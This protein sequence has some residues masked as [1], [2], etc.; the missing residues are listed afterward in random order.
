MSTATTTNTINKP[1][2]KKDIKINAEEC[3]DQFGDDLYEQLV[4]TFVERDYVEKKEQIEQAIKVKDNK[5]LKYVCHTFKTTSRMLCIEDFALECHAIETEAV[6]DNVD[7]NLMQELVDE[8]LI[9]FHSIYKDA[10]EI[11]NKEFNKNVEIIDK[12][13]K[14]EK[15]LKL[16]SR[17]LIEDSEN[18]ENMNIEESKEVSDK[19]KVIKSASDS[20]IGKFISLKLL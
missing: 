9:D 8:F 10:L 16:S 4:V 11:Y 15:E 6:K 19:K 20:E 3:K 7:W 12:D 18:M 13:D 2:K 17:T 1:T 5:Q 14:N